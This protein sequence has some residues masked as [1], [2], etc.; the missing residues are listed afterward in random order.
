M[1]VV[2]SWLRRTTKHTQDIVAKINLPRTE[3]GH[4]KTLQHI[5]AVTLDVGGT[6]ITPWPSV[7]HIYA[8]VAARSGVAGIPSEMLDARF[9]AAWRELKNFHH[10]REEWAALV[11]K[12]FDGLTPQSPSETFFPDLFQRFAEPAAWKIYDDVLPAIDA[13]AG[14]GINLG[15]ISNWDER[16]A[17][18]LGTIG[19]RKYFDSVVV[20]CEIGFPKPSPVIFEH[21]AR[22]LGVAPEFILH[23]GDSL[24]EDVEGA[25]SA[26][27]EALLIARGNG[28]PPPDA[29]KSLCDLE[30]LLGGSRHQ[31]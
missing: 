23:V 9:R 18:L 7:G 17:P 2:L 8:E 29:I 27:F 14:L 1:V 26:G 12:V 11:D 31:D 30:P 5:R 28:A 20:S 15:I 16:L 3:D 25:R 10:G 6:L 22:K 13:I 21:A 24:R 4:L 19:L